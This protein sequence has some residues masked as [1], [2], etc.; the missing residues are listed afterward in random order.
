[1]DE[2]KLAELGQYYD[3]YMLG[4]PKSFQTQQAIIVYKSIARDIYAVQSEELK[5]RLNFERFVAL[6]INQEV[7]EYLEKRQA[8]HPVVSPER[9]L[10]K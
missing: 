10:P 4:D 3:E 5:K 1:M 7:L 6:I 9:V 8:A 2:A